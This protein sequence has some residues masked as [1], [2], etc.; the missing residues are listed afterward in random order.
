LR[1]DISSS[2]PPGKVQKSPLNEERIG[3]KEAVNFLK[4]NIQEAYKKFAQ[5]GSMVKNYPWEMRKRL[6]E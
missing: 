1:K 6:L 4:R 3:F 2:G 5:T